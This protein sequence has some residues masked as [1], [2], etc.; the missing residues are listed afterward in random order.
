MAFVWDASAATAGSLERSLAKLS[1]EER[2]HQACAIKGLE[3]VRRGDKRLAKADRLMPDTFRRAHFDGSVVSAKGAAVRAN[4]HWYAL[5]F[6]CTVSDD[7]M[8][9]LVFTFKLGDEIPPET[10]EDVG[11]WR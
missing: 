8:K 3:A 9:A 10:W 5:T 2:A 7:Q 11:L 4:A 1:P 6:E